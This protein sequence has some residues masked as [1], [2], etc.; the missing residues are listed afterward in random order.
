MIEIGLCLG[1]NL[2]NRVAHLQRAAAAVDRIEGVSVQERSPIY[3]T[4]PVDVLPENRDRPFLNAVLIVDCS[5]DPRDLLRFL[6]AIENEMGRIRTD[7]R[8]AP[9]TID[10]D[11]LYAGDMRIEEDDLCV[12]H[13]QWFTRRFVVQPL[14]DLRPNLVI[15]DR[16]STVGEILLSLPDTS[17]VVLFDQHWETG[18]T[19]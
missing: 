16:E 18:K 13:P 2:G 12:P 7:D 15:P 9:R 1:S 17:K 11:I 8:N 10:I 19:P 5:L 14:A 6:H 3:E 4:E